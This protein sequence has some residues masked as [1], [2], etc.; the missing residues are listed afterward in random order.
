MMNRQPSMADADP[1]D[2]RA[3]IRHPEAELLRLYGSHPLAFFGLAPKNMHFLAPGGAGLVN[4]QLTRKVAV[5]LGDPVCAPVAGAP[6]G[7]GYVS[8]GM[9]ACLPQK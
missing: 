8:S 3:Q 5:V 7:K 2:Q 4:Y 6:N 1:K 9:K